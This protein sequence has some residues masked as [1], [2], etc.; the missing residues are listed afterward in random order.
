MQPTRIQEYTKWQ[1]HNQ[2]RT[3]CMLIVDI[4][5]SS[6]CCLC[7]IA[8]APNP[9]N[10]CLNCIRAQVDISEG[11]PKQ[12]V[13]QFC[14]GCERYLQP[15]KYWVKC[16]LESR[17][18]LHICLKRLKGL[19]K[20]KLVDANFIWT[21]PH[22]RRLKIKLTIQKEVFN[23]TVVQQ[24]FVVE[25]IVSTLQCEVCQKSYTENTWKAIVQVRQ[26]VRSFTMLTSKR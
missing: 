11:I 16:D 24:S 26:H 14:K 2:N 5:I 23:G 4:L 15:P 13:V 19:N 20:I 7:G 25:F 1:Q 21:E 9:A 10:M 3:K 12:E 6:L 17:E 18:L 8:I 22:S